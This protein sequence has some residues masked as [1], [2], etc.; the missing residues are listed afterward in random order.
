M[1]LFSLHKTVCLDFILIL[2]A[3]L[4]IL[5]VL[6]LN[7]S[8]E[9]QILSATAVYNEPFFFNNHLLAF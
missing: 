8:L 1:Q 6:C 7:G 2:E 4:H 3:L 9:Y 5:H